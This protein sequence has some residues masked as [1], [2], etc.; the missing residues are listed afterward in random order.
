MKK[1]I[2]FVDDQP[3]AW[4][5]LEPVANA[6]GEGWAVEFAATT[7]EALALQ[8]R[9]PCDAIVAELRLP[10]VN[11]AQFLNE[12][13]QRHPRT[14][15]FVMSDLSD[16]SAVMKCVG[17][18]HQFLRKPCDPAVLQVALQRALSLDIWLPNEAVTSLLAKMQRLPSPPGLYFQVVKELQSDQASLDQIGAIIARDPA[19]TAKI[20]QLVNS[21]VF[22]L[23][24]PV[25]S[26]AEAVLL[27]GV[28]TTKSLILLAHGYSYYSRLEK[29]GFSIDELWRHSLTTAQFAQRIAR[30]ELSNSFS[31]EEVY[32]AG[33]LHDMGKLILAANLPDQYRR[34]SQL[35]QTG[36]LPMWEAEQQ[37][38]GA[39][40]A[41][42]GACLMA[43]W[44]LPISIVETLALH[45]HPACLINQG[46]AALTAV[47]VANAIEHAEIAHSDQ[48]VVDHEY[49]A[50]IGLDNHLPAWRE[51]CRQ[52]SE[53]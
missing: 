32:T 46:F 25:N 49:L 2:L 27:L 40:H 5:E 47:H 19:M 37:V 45:H 31:V 14:I 26:P 33:L 48:I 1:R 38:F 17:T 15:R 53:P 36:K 34:A 44:G 50:G 18:A 22:G 11:G 10:V 43:I 30:C 23:P 28:E 24:Q 12:I 41:E 16:V 4:R 21:T 20:L 51:V 39:C 3:N 6:L 42:I 7:T 52:N 35:A 9:S 29:S 8:S 13:M